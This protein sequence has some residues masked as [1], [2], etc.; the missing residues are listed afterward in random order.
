MHAAPSTEGALDGFCRLL[1][2]VSHAL[3]RLDTRPKAF[4]GANTKHLSY[5]HAASQVLWKVSNTPLAISSQR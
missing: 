4:S 3:A 5:P 1:A 2:K